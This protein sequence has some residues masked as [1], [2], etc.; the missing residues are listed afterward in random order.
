MKNQ[1]K[2]SLCQINPVMGDLE[3]NLK[4]HLKA[5]A[6]ACVEGADLIIFSELSLV[7]YPPEDLIFKPSFH[8]SVQKILEKM[9]AATKGKEAGILV[10]VPVRL[11][12]GSVYNAAI[13]I[14]DGQI[15]GETFKHHLPNY[16]VF[17]EQRNFKQ[18]DFDGPLH[19][20]GF[21]LGVMICEDMWNPSPAAHLKENGAD[22]LIVLNGSPFE[23]GKIEKRVQVAKERIT[24]TGLPLIY[25]NLVGGQD[26]LVFDGHS[27]VLDDKGNVKAQMEGFVEMQITIAL[28]KEESHLD[29][30]AESAYEIG[31]AI[32]LM[33]QALVL[34]VQ[35]YVHKNGFKGVVLGLSGGVDSALVAAIAVDALGNDAV[36]A[37]MMPSKFT[38]DE[39]LEDAKNCADALGIK[40]EIVPIKELVTVFDESA[41]EMLGGKPEGITAENIQARLRGMLLMA[42]SNKTGFMV[43]STGNKSEM[44]VGYSTLYGDLCGGYAVIKDVYKTNV[45]SLCNY[46][47]QIST[48]GDV[49][50]QNILTKAPTAELSEGQKDADSLPPY[51]VLDAILHGFIEDEK[52]IDCLVGKGF[53]RALLVRIQS[54][55][56]GAEYKRRQSP[57]GVKVT[58]KNFG[59]DRRY[60]ITN[61]YRNN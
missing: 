52:S 29:I 15:I 21:A 1:L 34:G 2:I 13:L 18:A 44:S 46:R 4:K 40:Y 12:E 5:Y 20:R 58:V 57:P 32:D 31:S 10:G 43:L 27:F 42:Y 60:P 25:V 16:G 24:E 35:D 6:Q 11:K 38:S 33:Y 23:I 59:R 30:K 19:F 22:A 3:G 54:L 56:Y 51:D 47:N 28:L 8:V 39:S 26:E 14:E 61:M 37:I 36:H 53:D 7:G 49:I 45:Y 48:I 55:I 9:K 50:P 41:A 17:D